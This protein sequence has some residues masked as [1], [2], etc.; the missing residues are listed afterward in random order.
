MTKDCGQ[1][2]AHLQLFGG[3]AFAIAYAD[4][5]IAGLLGWRGRASNL[6]VS[7][8]QVGLDEEVALAAAG[9]IALQLDPIVVHL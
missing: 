7:Y 2:P 8:S 5:H 6:L 4:L 9:G 3:G 1:R